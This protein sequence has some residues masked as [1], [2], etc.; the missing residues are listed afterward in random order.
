MPQR[1]GY[2]SPPII[3]AADGTA[4]TTYTPRGNIDLVITNTAVSVMATIAGVVQVDPLNSI[5][6]A[7]V[8]GAQIDNTDTG[9]ADASDTRFVLTP[10]D[11]Y[12]F[13]WTGATPGATAQLHFDGVQYPLGKAPLE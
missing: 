1:F 8:N 10:G 5:G 13:T 6:L 7:T 2:T 9:Q 4:S 12:E 11:N 3:V